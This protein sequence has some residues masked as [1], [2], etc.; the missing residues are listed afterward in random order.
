MILSFP[1]ISWDILLWFNSNW[2]FQEKYKIASYPLYHSKYETFFAV[3]KYL[4]PGFQV[5][6]Q[7]NNSYVVWAEG[8]IQQLTYISHSMTIVTLIHS[9]LFQFHKAMG[10]IWGELARNLADSLIIP[11]DVRDYARILQD[12]VTELNSSDTGAILRSKMSLGNFWVLA[13]SIIRCW[14]RFSYSLTWTERSSK[15]F[16]SPVVR[17]PSVCM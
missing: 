14:R 6:L 3:D 17:R 2:N 12:L 5:C 16:W 9:A 13:P 15:L 1:L 7:L 8:E 4:D 11:F 10:Q